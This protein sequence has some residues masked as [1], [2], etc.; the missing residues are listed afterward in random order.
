MTM[1]ECVAALIVEKERILLGKRSQYRKFYPNI[2]DVFGG[3]QFQG[4]TTE[5]TLRRELFEELGI[6]PIE[7]QFLTSVDEPDPAKNGNGIYHFYLV[8]NWENEPQNLQPEEH[9]IVE[10]FEFEKAIKLPFAHPLYIELIE[11]TNEKLN[12]NLSSSFS[13]LKKMTHPKGI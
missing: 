3:H 8:T 2:W 6:V 7:F 9:E 12:S 11:F 1:R 5:E 13:Y 4:E 10:W